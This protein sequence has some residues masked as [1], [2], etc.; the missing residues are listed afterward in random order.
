MT[1]I[2]LIH[3]LF[4]SLSAP[5][6]LSAFGQREVL[7]P[8]LIGYGILRDGAPKSWT[9]VDQADHLASYVRARVA[10]AV[11]VVGH[12]V[13]GAV[14]VIFA[15]RH[16]ELARSLTSVEG[17]M[18]LSDAFWSQKIA[19][20]ALS[21]I[22]EEVQ[23]FRADVAAWIG[24]S[25]VSPSPFA[26]GTAASWLENQP[27]STLRVQA[28]AVVSATGEPSY[29]EYLR[30]VIASGLPVHLVAG[31][32]SRN[33][34]SVPDWLA[35]Q[36]RS[37]ASIAGTGHLMMLEDPELFAETLLANFHDGGPGSSGAWAG[38]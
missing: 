38:T 33:G 5:R 28:R 15:H 34:W 24:R 37:D 30:A 7:A 4:G 20:Q 25:G 13:G 10:G 35:A 12:S 36:V 11:H 6:I 23:G 22:E 27:V 26:L 31:A 2:L 8:D 32:R 29:L 17:N 1:P 19:T 14:A 9:L 3:G 16:A 18:T 21:E